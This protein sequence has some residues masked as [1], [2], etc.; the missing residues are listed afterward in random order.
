MTSKKLLN[1]LIIASLFIFTTVLSAEV[2]P[3]YVAST[4]RLFQNSEYVRKNPA[5]DFWALMPYYVPQQDGSACGIASMSMLINAARVHQNLS[6]SDALV[7]QKSLV[8]KL[9]IDYSKGLTLDKLGETTKKAILEY[10]F[11]GTVEVIHADGTS[12]QS[13]KI[14]EL[15]IKNE[16]SDRNFILA[17]YL[18]SEFTGDPEGAVGH[19]SPVAGFDAKNNKVLLMDVDREYYEPY[20]VSLDTFI[21]GIN[22]VDQSV[23]LN[24]G[25]VFVEFQ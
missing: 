5:P 11:N 1:N 7:T 3:K 12:A 14:R 19:I 18:Q 6:A 2:K 4:V 15:L 17:N 25:I 21:K 10:G 22:T 23:K 9:K 20:W 13:K 16:K 8:E 24:R